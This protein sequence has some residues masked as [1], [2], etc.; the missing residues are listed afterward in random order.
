MSSN[1]INTEGLINITC[2]INK[3]DIENNQ[4]I[5]CSQ[6]YGTFFAVS[7][8]LNVKKGLL[9]SMTLTLLNYK[10]LFNIGML[11]ETKNTFKLI[12]DKAELTLYLKANAGSH[13]NNKQLVVKCSNVPIINLKGLI[14]TREL[15][16]MSNKI[17]SDHLNEGVFDSEFYQRDGALVVDLERLDEM[18]PLTRQDRCKTTYSNFV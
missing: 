9:K 16:K 8:K 14:V 17:K 10:G 15:Q 5:Y 7:A 13:G 11:K 6:L 2:N 1:E 4:L 3:Q 12:G 18:P